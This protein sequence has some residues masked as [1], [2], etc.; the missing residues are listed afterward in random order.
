[1]LALIGW[2]PGGDREVFTRDELV[3][4]FSLEAISGGNAVFNPE[5]LDWFNQ[6]H[7]LRLPAADILSRLQGDFDKAGLGVANIG[8]V[9]RGRLEK[10]IDL[11]KPRARKLID[12]VELVRPFVSDA[13]TRDPA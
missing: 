6:Q 2:S 3:A 5:K 7:I 12:I 10:V 4:Q 11:V 8:P 9:E 13:I 1:F